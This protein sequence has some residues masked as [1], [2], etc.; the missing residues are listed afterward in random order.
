MR[1]TSVTGRSRTVTVETP[2]FANPHR[3]GG[4]FKFG[5][6]YLIERGLCAAVV[7]RASERRVRCRTLRVREQTSRPE[8][9]S[10][11][12]RVGKLVCP[13]G[14]VWK[15]FGDLNR[16]GRAAV[17]QAVS[18]RRFK[19]PCGETVSRARKKFEA[20]ALPTAFGNQTISRSARTERKER[21][22]KRDSRLCAPTS[23]QVCLYRVQSLLCERSMLPRR[24]HQPT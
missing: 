11:G 19:P 17:I 10:L 7:G 21:V 16:R 6:R 20:S 8:G 24:Q 22:T 13:V 18:S 3:C 9:R 5:G 23:R 15:G 1:L 4:A 2:G 12:F 14:P